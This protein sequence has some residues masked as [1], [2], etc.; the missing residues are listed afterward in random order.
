MPYLLS[1][2]GL[3]IFLDQ[4]TKLFVIRYVPLHTGKE[5][6]PGFLNLVHAR[7][8]GAAFSFLAS[9]DASWR[10]PFFIVASVLMIAVILFAYGKLRKE[11]IW[12]RTAYSL[13]V[14]GAAGNLVD[15][16]RLGA[17]VDFLDVYV[18]SY[19]WPAFN[20]ADSAITI[21]ALMLLLSLIK[22]R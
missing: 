20:V 11:D 6:I 3:I 12:T 10:A 15:R 2:C 14:A 5:I 17:V 22:Q 7:N 13:I 1:I 16:L 21:G 8:T 18:G 19:H 4:M 9:A